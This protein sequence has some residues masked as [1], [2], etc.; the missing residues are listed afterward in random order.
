LALRATDTGDSWEISPA[1][2]VTVPLHLV[3]TGPPALA[4]TPPAVQRRTGTPDTAAAV[5]DR[6]AAPA[7]VLYRAL[8][9]R[10]VD[11]AQ[12]DVAGDGRR[13]RAFLDS[14]LT[15]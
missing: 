6:L 11:D 9:H 2:P 1:P 3:D 5:S 4:A 10:R 12:L 15:P 14:R 7:A 13:V 8:W